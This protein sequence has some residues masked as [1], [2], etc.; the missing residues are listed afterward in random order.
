MD[1]ESEIWKCRSEWFIGLGIVHRYKSPQFY[2]AI[3]L[4]FFFSLI[5]P[6]P[7]PGRLPLD[8]D[9]SHVSIVASFGSALL[10]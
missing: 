6:P 3:T 1:D 10:H 8:D 2:E 5:V 7:S 4:Q 9:D